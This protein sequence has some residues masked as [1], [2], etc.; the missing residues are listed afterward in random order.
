MKHSFQFVVCGLFAIAAVCMTGAAVAAPNADA[1]RKPAPRKVEPIKLDAVPEKGD[2]SLGVGFILN[3]PR[4]LT[5]NL[6]TEKHEKPHVTWIDTGS[7]SMRRYVPYGSRDYSDYKKFPQTPLPHTRLLVRYPGK[8]GQN[9]IDYSFFPFI[10]RGRGLYNWSTVTN[11]LDEWHAAYGSATNRAFKFEYKYDDF[12]DS[13]QLYLDNQFAGSITNS[14]PIKKL[15]VRGGDAPTVKVKSSY[16]KSR[17]EMLLPQLIPSRAHPLLKEGAKLSLNPGVRNIA[18][19]PIRVFSPENS[20]DTGNHFETTRN[21]D[22]GW[23]AMSSRHAFANGPNFMMYSIPKKCYSYA[24][25]LCADIPQEGRVPVL[26]TE[27]SRRGNLGRSSV[28]FDRTTVTNA[29]KSLENGGWIRKV[30]SLT[31]FKDKKKVKTPLYLVKHRLDFGKILDIINDPAVFGKEGTSRLH[32]MTPAVGD[33]LDFEFV[34][35]GT[36]NGYERSSLQIFGA[37]LV[38]TPYYIEIAQTENGNIFHNDEKPETG[39]NLT[40]RFDDTKGTVKVEIFDPYFKTLDTR[41][42]DF[43][44]KKAGV[45]E[46]LLLPLQMPDAGWYGF[47][48][49]FLDGKGE[50]LAKH[51]GAFALL[52]KDTREAGFESPFAA[53][54]HGGGYHNN[55]PHH[56]EVAEMMFKGGFRKTW[57][58]DFPVNSEDNPWKISLSMWHVG[59][60]YKRCTPEELKERLDKRVEEFK[61]IRQRFPHCTMIQLLHE[62]GGRDLAPEML[63]YKAVRG[64]YKG[65]DSDWDIVWCTEASKR[66]RKE[67]PDCRIMIGNGSSSSEKVADLVSRGFDLSL[68]DYL[69]IESKGFQTMPELSA[70]REAPGMAWALRETGRRFGYDLP[71]SACHEYVFRP[72]REMTPDTVMKPGFDYM[73]V[74][75]FTVRDYLISLGH[76][77]KCISTGH[78]EDTLGVYYDTNW[79]AGGMCKSYP[80]SYPK[81][82]YVALAALT[83]VMDKATMLRR[84][85]TGE[86]STYALEFRRDRKVKDYAYAFWT[87]HYDAELSLRFPAGTDVTLVDIWGRER[88]VSEDQLG[89]VRVKCG[90]SASYVIATKK[91]EEAKVVKHSQRNIKGNPVPICR[92]STMTAVN[93]MS[94]DFGAINPTPG[95]FNLRDVKTKDRGIVLEAELVKDARRIPEVVSEYQYL[96]LH[97]P[98]KLNHAQVE[99]LGI[100]VNGNGSFGPMAMVVRDSK[101]RMNRLGLGI[102]DFDGWHLLQ[103]S[104]KWWRF[105]ETGNKPDDD[106]EIMGF[107]ISSARQNLDPIE[108][109]PIDKPVQFSDIV[110]VPADGKDREITEIQR[111]QRKQAED[112]MKTVN[113]KDL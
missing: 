101:G 74:T 35:N 3:N 1:A 14:G 17:P 46:K 47:K 106:F 52:G 30:G 18:G 63:N 89:D 83:K 111:R 61:E 7:Q 100:W 21:G 97:R 109:R 39:V 9:T 79:G 24:Y 82:M 26:G 108:M 38:E 13:V 49:T 57:Y 75:D 81:R 15:E 110:V 99:K 92:L 31:Y 34:G 70:N 87:P 20:M 65:F 56:E 44:L 19:I 36:W 53:W 8:K 88:K 68:V 43:T 78:I 11:K 86:I 96:R 40:P 62:Q 33:Y 32:R 50:L 64:E 98:I 80:F 6:H 95:V 102:V 25:V 42:H 22:L 77:M 28:A 103:T 5:F 93:L 23:R 104:S 76:G 27:L 72:E 66:M 60:P 69:G 91:V 10:D 85:P 67:F 48:M 51:E 37:T 107:F 4:R 71:V 84:V 16:T 90:S 112:V 29:V 41:V 113:D 73:F 59:N 54:P 45:A 2:N 12:T 94:A 55:N 58:P 105:A